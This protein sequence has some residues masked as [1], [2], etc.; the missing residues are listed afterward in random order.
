MKKN[1]FYILYFISGVLF[2]ITAVLNFTDNKTL[3][4]ITYICLAITFT[5]LGFSYK[6]R[7]NSHN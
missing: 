1:N 4:G 7:G 3:M 6:K 5:S 2:T